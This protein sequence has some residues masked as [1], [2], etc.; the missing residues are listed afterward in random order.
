MNTELF[1]YPVS[2]DE[3]FITD[4]IESVTEQLAEYEHGSLTHFDLSI[5]YPAGL[6]GAV[7]QVMD[8]IPYGETRTYGDI[9]ADLDTAPIAIGQ[10]CGRNPI[11]IIVPCHRVIKTNGGLGGYSAGGEHNLVLK[12]TLLEHESQRVSP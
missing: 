11:P 2:I 8:T 7:M 3:T 6:T 10:A 4:P 5:R 1:G 12:R 9:A